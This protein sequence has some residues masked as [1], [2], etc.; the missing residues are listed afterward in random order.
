MAR[1]LAID[2]GTARIGISVSDSTGLL[3]RSLTVIRRVSDAKAVDSIAELVREHDVDEVVVGLPL[4]MNGSVGERAEMCRAFA[5]RIRERIGKP[6]E[7]YD[8]RLTTVAAERLLIAADVRRSKRKQVVD[9][10]AAT[11]LL[12][13]Y[14]D[15]RNRGRS[16]S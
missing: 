1:F 9:A 12:Q 2:Y 15:F 14:L 4:H 11:V 7:M 3:A 6:V 5:Q 8:E 16:D 13:S 10:V